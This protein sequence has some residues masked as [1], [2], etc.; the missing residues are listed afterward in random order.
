[1]T[2]DEMRAVVALCTFE[3]YV[4]KVGEKRGVPYLQAEYVEA[5]ISTG[6]SGLQLTRKWMLSGHMVQSEIVQTVF[7][8]V[9]T[10]MEH[11]A[12]EHF[13]FRGA[14]IFGPHFDVDALVELVRTKQFD[15]RGKTD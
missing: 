8:C 11:R 2:I 13:K 15:Y 10:S 12:R 9:M 1:M 4:F 6:Q 14:R 5:D 3:D 7:K